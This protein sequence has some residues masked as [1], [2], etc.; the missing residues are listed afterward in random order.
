M[1]RNRNNALNLNSTFKHKRT[2]TFRVNIAFGR[3][4]LDT[5]KMRKWFAF[6]NGSQDNIKI[7]T[8]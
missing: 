7:Y 8:Q 4:R 6:F 3:I 1:L 2:S 5:A